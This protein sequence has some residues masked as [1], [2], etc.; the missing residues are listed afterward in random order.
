[1]KQYIKTLALLLLVGLGLTSCLKDDRF[2]EGIKKYQKS[3][4]YGVWKSASDASGNYDY[5]AVFTKDAKGKDLF[6]VVRKARNSA[7]DSGEVKFL[8]VS[9]DVQYSDSTGVIEAV[10][11]SCFFGDGQNGTSKLSARAYLAILRSSKNLMF[12]MIT[13]DGSTQF[14]VQA[15]RDDA[16]PTSIAGMWEGYSSD[17][18]KY[19]TAN[20]NSASAQGKGSGI[21]VFNDNDVEDVAYQFAGNKGTVTGNDTH[22]K[23]ELSFNDEYQLVA[24]LDGK[25]F[26]VDPLA[27]S[28]EPEAFTPTYSA[29]FTSSL[30]GS[31]QNVVIYKGEKNVGN[32]YFKPFID[33]NTTGFAFNM[34]S[35]KTLSFDSKNGIPTG[36]THVQ[37]GQT[38]GPVYAYDAYALGKGAQSKYDAGVFTFNVSYQIPGVGG[39]GVFAEKLTITGTASPA[40]VAKL[41][42]K[43]RSSKPFHFNGTLQ[44]NLQIFAH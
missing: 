32:Y 31:S 11:P 20:L 27:S 9:H 41:D 30:F 3:L 19:F 22:K 13:S 17:S 2:D 35:D 14:S 12:Q 26:V 18:T 25:T 33:N 40:Q 8:M 28:S 29:T 38:L 15:Q 4:P 42:L 16:K 44:H 37:G 36:Y 43:S 10:A 34:Q 24:T 23:A 6:Y 1:M 39:F 7:P 21:A 5:T